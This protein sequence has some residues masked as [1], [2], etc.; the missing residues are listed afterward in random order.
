MATVGL[1]AEAFDFYDALTADNTKAFWTEHKHEYE[2]LVKE[3]MI[4]LGEALTDE[5]GKPHLYRPYRDVRFSKDKTPYKDHQGLYIESRNGL[6]WYVQVSARGLMV[7]GGWYVSTPQQVAKYRE[8]VD[9]DDAGE[10][11]ALVAEV[12]NLGYEVGGELLKTK[13]RGYDKDHPRVQWLRYRTMYASHT[14][15]P[16]A[17]METDQLHEKV[18]GSWRAL[19]GWMDWLADHVGPGETPTGSTRNPRKS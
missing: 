6:G 15:E 13:P 1:P 2:Q 18:A 9:T 19:S 3:P 4:A 12:E 10:L 5:F 8:A 16:A 14:W 11:E 7:A 17:W